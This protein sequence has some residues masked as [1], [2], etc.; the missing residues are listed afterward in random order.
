[1][2]KF[3]RQ[4]VETMER[5]IT[6]W[7]LVGVAVTL[8]AI[9]AYLVNASIVNIVTAKTVRTHVTSLTTRVGALESSYLTAKSAITIEEAR[10]LG[11]SASKS[12]PAYIGRTATLGAISLNR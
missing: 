1:M 7:M 5:P 2:T 4:Q 8:I 3:V 9:Y 6:A 12:R 11:F 10:E